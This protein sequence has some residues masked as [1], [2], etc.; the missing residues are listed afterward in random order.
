MLYLFVHGLSISGLHNA[1]R[2]EG[3]GLLREVFSD[4]AVVCSAQRTNMV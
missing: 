2:I 3:S 4:L 1:P